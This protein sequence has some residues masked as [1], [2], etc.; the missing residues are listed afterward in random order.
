MN[1]KIFFSFKKP[2]EILITSIYK[3]FYNLITILN[4]RILNYYLKYKDSI[5]V[6][7]CQLK[8]NLIRI[9]DGTFNII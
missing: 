7:Y 2:R 3:T 6:K 5:D 8:K 4:Y 1:R 9:R